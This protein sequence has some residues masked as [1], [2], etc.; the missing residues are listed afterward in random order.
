M[1]LTEDQFGQLLSQPVGIRTSETSAAEAHLLACE[2][3]AAELAGLRDSLSLFRQASTTYANNELRNLPPMQLPARPA[4]TL[5]VQPA[6]WATAAAAVILAFLPMQALRQ[7][8]FQPAP[9]VAASVAD[10][11][12]QTEDEALLNDVDT[13]ISAS[14]P[15]PMLA[16]AD[17]AGV[18]SGSLDSSVPTSTQRKD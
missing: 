4:H 15:T 12:V 18:A 13:E 2:Q 3:C 8:S 7:H 14:V 10:R 11:T 9:A 5:A 6:Y 17:P 1:H 16:L